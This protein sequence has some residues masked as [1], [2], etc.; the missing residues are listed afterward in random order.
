MPDAKLTAASGTEGTEQ[1]SFVGADGV[2][3]LVDADSGERIEGVSPAPLDPERWGRLREI[4][5]SAGGD[6]FMAMSRKAL[7]TDDVLSPDAGNFS[8]VVRGA[9]RLVD[10]A[11]A[12]SGARLALLERGPGRSEIRLLEPA[13]GD[14]GRSAPLFA[15]RGA[16]TEITWSPDG[17]WLLAGWRSADQWLFLRSERPRRLVAIDELSDQFHPGDSGE[18]EFPRA[19]GWILPQR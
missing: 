12:P 11:L 6:R 17:R 5:W 2:S 1:L 13:R 18:A 9:A 15:G 19:E 8:Y 7:L 4:A 10:A 16:L 14:G 3:R